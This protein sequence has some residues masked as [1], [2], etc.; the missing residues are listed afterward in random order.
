M[1]W[2]SLNL[3][4]EKSPFGNSHVE[5]Y[6]DHQWLHV[7]MGCI[8]KESRSSHVFLN[9]FDLNLFMIATENSSIFRLLTKESML[10]TSTTLNKIVRMWWIPRGFCILESKSLKVSCNVLGLE[11]FLTLGCWIL[12]WPWL[13]LVGLLYVGE[14][15]QTLQSRMSQHRYDAKDPKYR[16]LYNHFNQPGHDRCLTMKVW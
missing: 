7:Q 1:C 5:W 4:H 3:G 8:E 9:Q 11:D 10:L 14:T 16:I 13:R 15:R 6:S 2:G 12:L